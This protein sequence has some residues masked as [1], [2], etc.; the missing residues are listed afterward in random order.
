MFHFPSR[1]TVGQGESEYELQDVD[2][3]ADVSLGKRLTKFI[4]EMSIKGALNKLPSIERVPIGRW[5]I[6]P[7]SRKYR[8]WWMFLVIAAAY[9]SLFTPLEFGFYRGL[10]HQ[11]FIADL[12]TQAI[13]IADILVNFFLAY[14]DPESYKL[15]IDFPS[16]A[17]RYVKSDFILDVI[18]C[19][20]WDA[21]YK[22]S[23]RYEAVRYFVLFRVYRV[24]KVDGFFEKLEKDIRIN[25]FATRIAKLLAVEFYCT[26]IAACIFYYLATT[27]PERS[28][29][30]TWIGSL[31]L[32]DYNYENFRSIDIG[33]RYV[34]SMYWAIVTMATVGYGDIHA[35]NVREMIFV[36]M[37][38]SFDMI[39]GAYLV[40]NMTALIVKG[41]NTERFRDKM[42]TLIKFMNRNGLQRDIRQQMKSH[43]RLQFET[44]STTDMSVV[45][46][47]PM[48][49]RSKVA[50]SL[51]SSVVEQ[52][53]LFAGCSPEFISQIVAK[54][55]EE[56]FLPGE[57]VIQQGGTSDQFYIVVHGVLEEVVITDEGTEDVI[58][59]LESESIC[60]EVGVLCNIPQPFTVRVLEL[61][62]LLRIDKDSFT[63]IVQIYFN[64]GRTLINNL[65]EWKETDARFGQLATDI[66]F[67]VAKQQAELALMVNNAAF[68]GDIT[69]LKHLVKAGAVAD[70]ADY[71]GR[72]PLHL[73]ASKGYEIVVQFLIREGADVNAIDK[74]GCSPLF[75]AV[76]G[77]NDST[78]AV[79]VE[80]GAK[81]HLKDA[82]SFM[83][84]AVVRGNHEL[85]R[86]LVEAGVNLSAADYDHR[87]ALHLAAAEGSF[88]CTKLLLESGADVFAQDRWG[89]TPLDEAVMHNRTSIIPLLRDAA[90]KKDQ[91]TVREPKS[92]LRARK[93]TPSV[94]VAGE[95]QEEKSSRSRKA[96]DLSRSAES[97]LS[98]ELQPSEKRL[99]RLITLGV[100]APRSNSNMSE[101][102]EDLCAKY[103]NL[104]VRQVGPGGQIPDLSF[105][106]RLSALPR[107]RC[108]IFPYH[109]WTLRSLRT[110][111]KVEWVPPTIEGILD[112]AFHEFGKQATKVVNQD[113]GEITSSDLIG[114]MEKIYVVDD[115]D[116]ET[117]GSPVQSPAELK[118]T[119]E[120]E[121]ESEG[122]NTAET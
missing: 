82:G 17:D 59:R 22:S 2:E 57:V 49:I 104:P 78:I 19:L 79:L 16:I 92:T 83:C 81:L 65:L 42:T 68:Q 112:V 62:R 23:G 115:V 43:V 35:V 86:R 103:R 11:L 58:S 47:L 50:Q 101:S 45:D 4:R 36:M 85:L 106:G 73:A 34:T 32:G 53:P 87:T 100:A 48:T 41:S 20:P 96:P 13:F 74:F 107:R 76:K 121:P 28:E 72:T 120:W 39:L 46:D 26:H 90:A 102:S 54:V 14:R 70:R 77:G 37:Y 12:A 117:A 110:L 111:G 40:G 114:D 89:R 44:G 91:V 109:P 75:E 10:P 38:I 55:N 24:R 18:A 94:K 108:T 99:E 64:D 29:K 116:L 67:L 98:V 27:V 93:P 88:L 56:Y 8:A 30:Y 122:I 71:D 33:K 51:Y 80:S 60:G 95:G 97:S 7:Y 3:A 15:V 52:A 105:F 61:C 5:Y 113:C 6:S 119:P 9:S 84:Q 118:E 69:Q 31:Q 66:T 25:Y 63:H 21:I 1:K